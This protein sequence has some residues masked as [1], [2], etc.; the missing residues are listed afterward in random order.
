MVELIQK[1]DDLNKGRIK[2]NE[3]I[4]DADKAKTDSAQALLRAIDS[5]NLSEQTQI[6]LTQAIL[7]GDSSPLGGQL[8]VGAD[9]TVYPGPQ[10]RL[11]AENKKLTTQL[12]E[13]ATEKADKTELTGFQTQINNLVLQA[14]NPEATAAEIE[15]TRSAYP[16][17]ND[18][19][20]VHESSL[21]DY[22]EQLYGDVK[23]SLLRGYYNTLGEFRDLSEGISENW[24]HFFFYTGSQK[25]F[26]LEYP[27]D[28]TVRIIYFDSNDNLM[29]RILISNGV[30][31]IPEEATS[32][33]INIPLPNS[34]PA[35]DATVFSD[36]NNVDK[37]TIK[38]NSGLVDE[39]VSLKDEV[40]NVEKVI[41]GNIV[42]IPDLIANKYHGSGDGLL[43][44]G[45]NWH[46][47]KI[48]VAE[49]EDLIVRFP[50]NVSIRWIEF[51]SS[52]LVVYSGYITTNQKITT[53]PNV[54][55]V[56][57]NFPLADA[58]PT[59]G[60]HIF[61][62]LSEIQTITLTKPSE[63]D[64]LGILERVETLEKTGGNG[65]E[66]ENKTLKVLL[67]GNSFSVDATQ[68]LYDIAQSAGIDIVVGC[69]Y[70]SGQ[71]LQGAWEKIQSGTGV[72]AYNK[73]TKE[74][75]YTSTPNAL[76][77][78]I[79]LDEEWDIITY[80]QVSG[81]SFDY[82]TFQPY[83]TE[84]HN[85]IKGK[86][87]NSN[88]KYGFQMT[89]AYANNYSGLTNS[90]LTQ[91]EMFDGIADAFQR[92]MQDMDFDVL[93]PTGTAI[94]NARTSTYLQAVG[95][96]MTR[97]GYH[98]DMGVS[99]Y[100]AA[101]TVFETLFSGYYNKDIMT[102]APFYTTT[103]GGTKFLAYLG[104]LAVKNA[105]MNPFKISGI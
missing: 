15:Q 64:A 62:S 84:M 5:M 33:A 104:K 61:S 63:T 16:V 42:P 40:D 58:T 65:T 20:S 41:F 49:L 86:V 80:Q 82:S 28:I 95:D 97:D 100:I 87:T 4:K 101:L 18:R 91:L 105:V 102:E 12:A 29:S 75:G 88:C 54:K 89:W 25:K 59:P 83:L 90:G 73:W 55:Y 9:S 24:Y 27:T 36:F 2:L 76:V 103:N 85:Y 93:L 14:G 71:D 67:I 7:E 38:A 3:A 22:K 96:D 35:T 48:D 17:M 47:I 39:V 99:R 44:S 43:K 1:D 13:T 77:S 74:T 10:E 81:K 50:T 79:I 98:L 46:T 60:G 23:R 31:S 78:N 53:S 34:L 92:A 66:D 51:D 72:T 52:N 30:F 32:F 56:A 6:E 70:D 57:M 68:Y 45:A 19:V 26:V 8:S 94:Q 37:V 11:I 69:A 21:N